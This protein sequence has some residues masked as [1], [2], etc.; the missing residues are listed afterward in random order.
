MRKPTKKNRAIA[1]KDS[2]RSSDR[3]PRIGVLQKGRK[4]A[5]TV[6]GIIGHYRTIWNLGPKQNSPVQEIANDLNDGA[7]PGS[8]TPSPLSAVRVLPTCDG[9]T[10]GD[11]VI[12]RRYVCST[13][14]GHSAERCWSGLDRDCTFPCDR[15]RRHTVAEYLRENESRRSLKF[16]KIENNHK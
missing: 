15:T 4:R 14:T 10:P 12:L 5:R 11:S 3:F 7:L 6:G 9:W 2:F 13:D 1:I 16:T 8:L